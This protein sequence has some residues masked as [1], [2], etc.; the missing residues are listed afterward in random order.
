[1][2]KL[3]SA[4]CLKKVTH[5]RNWLYIYAVCIRDFDSLNLF[6]G[7][8]LG[9]SQSLKTLLKNTIHVVSGQ[10]CSKYNHLAYF[11]EV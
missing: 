9:S 6:N 5:V 1:M 4:V 11:S 7:S 8:I 10:K 2:A 3:A